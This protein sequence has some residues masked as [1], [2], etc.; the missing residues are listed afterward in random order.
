MARAPKLVLASVKAAATTYSFR[1][2]DGFGSWA[3]CTV[4]D[5]TGELFI[6]SDW[7]GW[8][9]RWNASPQALGAPTLTAFI[10]RGDVDYLARKLQR[11]GH[12][13]RRFS[14]E[15][16]ARAL[17]RLLRERRLN[18]GR[19]QLAGRLEDDDFHYGR[20]LPHLQGLYTDAGLPL[21]GGWTVVRQAHTE[22]LPYLTADTARQIW[23]AIGDLANELDRSN[24]DLFYERLFAIP[25]FGDYVTN[26]PWEHGET[27]QTPEDKALRDIVLPALIQECK[28]SQ[29]VKPRLSEVLPPHASR[30][31][32]DHVAAVVHDMMGDLLFYDRKESESLP[33]HDIED[34]IIAG[35]VTVDEIVDVVRDALERSVADRKESAT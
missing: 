19:C 4:N 14:A 6:S 28:V 25:G 11:E 30:T 23:D 5:Q 20:P 3:L 15:N 34:A 17:R 35:E 21:F 27:E 7:G 9:H 2:E 18:D 33:M 26:E 12:G 10:G 22:R 13:G 16:T 1:A 29:V 8:S 31:R 32:R 24:G